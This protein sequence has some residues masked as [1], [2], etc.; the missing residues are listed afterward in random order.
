MAEEPWKTKALPAGGLG[1]PVLLGLGIV[2]VNFLSCHR[3]VHWR[4]AT[5]AASAAE[6]NI[7]L[8]Y[9]TGVTQTACVDA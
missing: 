2:G 6:R 8:H 9:S 1:A 5:V 4:A 3:E 7:D